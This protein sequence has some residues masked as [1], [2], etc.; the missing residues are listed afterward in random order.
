MDWLKLFD[1]TFN[2]AMN[3]NRTAISENNGKKQ[4]N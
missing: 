2:F 4:K 3:E 1:T